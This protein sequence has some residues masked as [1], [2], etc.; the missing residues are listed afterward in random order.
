MDLNFFQIINI[1]ANALICI[2]ITGFF[3]LLFGNS[4]SII[5]KWNIL[6]HW[7]LKVTLVS[8]IACS[9]WNALHTVYT[10]IVPRGADYV[11]T[12]DAPVGEVLLNVGLAFLFSWIV[13]FHKSHFLKVAPPKDTTRRTVAK[14][15]KVAPKKK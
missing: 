14:K 7:S 13:Y 4:H 2:G 5:Q 11:T 3:V 9:A 8:I 6:Q 15:K 12:V 1:F 10:K